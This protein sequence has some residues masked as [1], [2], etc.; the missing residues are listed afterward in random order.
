MKEC[1]V[2]KFWLVII[3]V[4]LL[5]AFAACQ[6]PSSGEETPSGEDP[7]DPPF[8]DISNLNYNAA[9]HNAADVEEKG[10]LLFD[11]LNFNLIS[12]SS[13]TTR[14]PIF[15]V[16]YDGARLASIEK[17]SQGTQYS[18]YWLDKTGQYTIKVYATFPGG[19]N[20]QGGFTLNVKPG[21]YPDKVEF[22]LL[23]MQRQKVMQAKGGESFILVAKVFS[24][25]T[26]LAEDNEKFSSSWFMSQTG[27][28]EMV[29]DIPNQITDTT[30][31]YAFTYTCYHAGGSSD[32]SAG[33]NITIKNNYQGLHFDY[34][35]K[36]IDGAAVIDAA[37]YGGLINFMHF[38][39][40]KHVFENGDEEIIEVRYETDPK[41]GEIA[42]FIKCDGDTQ[43]RRYKRH[44]YATDVAS[45]FANYVSNGTVYQIDPK[46]TS[47]E[48]YLAMCY[49]EEQQFGYALKYRPID[50][51]NAAIT[52][53][54]SVPDGISVPSISGKEKHLESNQIKDA[55]EFNARAVTNN[56]VEV[57]VMVSEKYSEGA[58]T[59]YFKPNVVLNGDYIMGDYYYEIEND[60]G[61]IYFIASQNY[62]GAHRV[63]KSFLKVKSCFG[64]AEYTFEI[65]AVNPII[66]YEIA[67]TKQGY[68]DIPNYFCGQLNIVPY[69]TV[70]QNYYNNTKEGR[71]VEATESLKYYQDAQEK[72]IEDF[73]FKKDKYSISIKLF[74][75]EVEKAKNTIA[76][77]FY[78]FPDIRFELNGEEYQISQM[79]K[80]R[81]AMVI[82]DS[83]EK[84]FDFVG[85]LP[86]MRIELEKGQEADRRL[87]DAPEGAKIIYLPGYDAYHICYEG[88]FWTDQYLKRQFDEFV[89]A[90]IFI[91]R[92][93]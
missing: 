63:G 1:A 58:S 75:N 14:S 25:D 32:K 90:K 81:T 41:E 20:K 46:K 9:Y 61:L 37:E 50:G 36:F 93:E 83:M 87:I 31:L 59:Q 29:V 78:M 6:P 12:F 65:N 40:A 85:D 21:G 66:S 69:V 84:S 27:E 89:V 8:F 54:K 86:V 55:V 60:T 15:E 52:I 13:T 42:A 70:Y 23:N 43:F 91:D 22:E 56:S 92:T 44:M 67:L 88:F 18:N 57:K 71:A 33:F 3:S 77:E 64:N 51:T 45:S 76:Y 38:V 39:T 82:C 74:E 17:S 79:E 4:L 80:T 48:I 53:N 11:W 7:Q 62:F 2:K 35:D 30:K 5:F 49:K 19:Q 16:Y 28:R 26:L 73:V 10:F 24:E 47:A 72:N 68:M 34:G